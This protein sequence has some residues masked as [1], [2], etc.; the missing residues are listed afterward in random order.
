MTAKEKMD[1][2]VLLSTLWLFAMLTYTNGD[3]VT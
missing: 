1:P 2:K 3:V